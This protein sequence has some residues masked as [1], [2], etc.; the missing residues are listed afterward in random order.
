M[1]ESGVEVI[2]P[3]EGIEGQEGPQCF[4]QWDAAYIECTEQCALSSQ[5]KRMT[6]QAP[7]AAPPTKPLEEVEKLP[8]ISPYEFLLQSLKG[9][10]NVKESTGKKNFKIL[11][12]NKEGYG[13]VAQIGITE[14]GRYCIKTE[15]VKLQIDEIDSVRQAAEIFKAFLII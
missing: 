9:R 1:S 7:K 12:C 2:N 14:A 11:I 8:E 3:L 5:C 13:D 6:E 4:G 10:Y 15:K